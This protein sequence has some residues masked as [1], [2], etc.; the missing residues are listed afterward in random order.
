MRE[1]ILRIAFDRLF[2]G[3]DEGTERR[4]EIQI[5]NLALLDEICLLFPLLFREICHYL[6]PYLL[7]ANCYVDSMISPAGVNRTT[8]LNI[9][10]SKM[11]V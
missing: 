9:I 6:L 4:K 2:I 1:H 5:I 8:I 10:F 11:L 3:E 7:M